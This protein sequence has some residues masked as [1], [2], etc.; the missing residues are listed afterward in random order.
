MMSNQV[1]KPLGRTICIAGIFIY[2]LSACLGQAPTVEVGATSITAKA[3]HVDIP[4]LT[5]SPSIQELQ[6]VDW[7]ITSFTCD[8]NGTVENVTIEVTADG[9]TLPY[10]YTMEGLVESNPPATKHVSPTDAQTIATPAG[11][12]KNATATPVVPTDT[13]IPTLPP[14]LPGQFLVSVGP[15]D[16]KISIQSADGQSVTLDVSISSVCSELNILQIAPTA[17]PP[18]IL[19]LTSSPQPGLTPTATLNLPRRPAC[20]DGL[21]NDGDGYVDLYDP[22]CKGKGDQDES[23]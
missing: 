10:A 9:G 1:E 2:L 7:R 17:A 3:T 20:S 15:G 19:S 6:V 11:K 22:N 8:K 12:Q 16:E 18:G 5:P 4:I 14:L 13:P 23:H 21:D